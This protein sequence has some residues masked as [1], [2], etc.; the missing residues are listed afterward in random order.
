MPSSRQPLDILASYTRRQRENIIADFERKMKIWKW[1][2]SDDNSEFPDENM[3]PEMSKFSKSLNDSPRQRPRSAKK[4]SPMTP[5]PRESPS[6]KAT[7]QSASDSKRVR[8]PTRVIREQQEDARLYSPSPSTE[9][10]EEVSSEQRR[11]STYKRRAHSPVDGRKRIRMNYTEVQLAILK[12]AFDEDSYAN[13]EMKE[14]LAEMTGLSFVQVNKW[15]ENRRKRD[16]DEASAKKT[17]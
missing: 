16:R 17:D 14:E 9:G 1:I 6:V 4:P 3:K 5:Q 8:K 12:N 10:S 11:R 2:H 7:P 15:F 13:R